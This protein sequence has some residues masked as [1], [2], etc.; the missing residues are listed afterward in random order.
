MA[1]KKTEEKIPRPKTIRKKI[2]VKKI[3]PQAKEPVASIEEITQPEEIVVAAK[4]AKEVTK[5]VVEKP[6]EVEEAGPKEES[7]SSFQSRLA[8]KLAATDNPT[9]IKAHEPGVTSEIA[10]ATLA[11]KQSVIRNYLSGVVHH[12]DKAIQPEVPAPATINLEKKIFTPVSQVDS[13]NAVPP[14]LK[15]ST[16][17][18]GRSLGLYR[19]I[20]ISFALPTLV[21]VLIL[22]Y[23]SCV[24]LYVT[25]T[26][27]QEKVA[28]NLV[29]DIYNE[30]SEAKPSGAAGLVRQ[31][32]VTESKSASS[33]GR[34]VTGAQL[35]GRAKIINNY[36]KSQSLVAKTRLLSASGKLY[37][38][39]ES[40]DVA[41]GS[42][43]EVDIYA[44]ELKKENEVEA[45][46][47]TI[48]GLW[49]GLQD[50]IYAESS[51]PIQY[52]EDGAPV[53]AQEDIDKVA[54]ELKTTLAE[55][56]KNELTPEEKNK[57]NQFLYKL[58]ETSVISE[59]DAKPGDERASVNVTVKGVVSVIAF[60]DDKIKQLA[61]D[62]LNTYLG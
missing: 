53:V 56:A 52:A 22:A 13:V 12:Q 8:A 33:S 2:A 59:A 28:S 36:N 1:V 26:P 29:A 9:I 32:A 4:K 34:N 31:V 57:Y 41:A 19:K 38:L 49:A 43:V 46:K 15:Q 24:K 39:K 62:K 5:V 7:G 60:S 54:E 50:K 37:R 18:G 30:G 40:V 6:D 35:V 25:I 23:F 20:L 10:P 51:E 17:A 16:G 55:Q 3:K 61:K 14:M 58:D 45:T 27:K 47:F 21:L 44:D 48:P 11:E 42:S